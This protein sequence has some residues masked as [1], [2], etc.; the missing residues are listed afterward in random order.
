MHD[1]DGNQTQYYHPS[2]NGKVA[3]N[4]LD[5][6][7]CTVGYLSAAGQPT[8]SSLLLK[9]LSPVAVVSE[10]RKILDSRQAGNA[11]PDCRSCMYHWTF[12][13]DR[14]SGRHP[15]NDAD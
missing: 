4:K 1:G 9:Y 14:Q 7:Y 11:P 6:R 5:R 3:S 10:L 8:Q 12:F 13:A 15:E 2:A